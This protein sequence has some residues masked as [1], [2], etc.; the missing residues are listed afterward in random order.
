MDFISG[1]HAECFNSFSELIQKAR[2]QQRY[3]DQVSWDHILD[4]FNRY[5]VWAASSGA[6]QYGP[7][8]TKSLDYRLRETSFM[9]AQ[10]SNS[11]CAN[12]L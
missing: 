7:N 6:G 12:L 1:Y 11:G 2:S 4:E 10:V 9:K 3:E 5:K 8:Y